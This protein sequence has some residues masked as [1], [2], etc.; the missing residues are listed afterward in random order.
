VYGSGFSPEIIAFR[1]YFDILLTSISG[2]R[3]VELDIDIHS[4]EAFRNIAKILKAICSG[5]SN[6]LLTQNDVPKGVFST[7]IQKMNEISDVKIQT[8]SEYE[9]IGK[10][11]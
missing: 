2:E 9:T 4:L 10:P 11:D 6:D 7:V 1:T 3:R 5:M 8:A